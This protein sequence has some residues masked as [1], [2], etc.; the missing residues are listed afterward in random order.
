[1]AQALEKIMIEGSM[2]TITKIMEE[3][4]ETTEIETI[5]MEDPE[6]IEETK[7]IIL[8]ISFQFAFPQMNMLAE[9]TEMIEPVMQAT[10]AT[11]TSF[12]GLGLRMRWI[13]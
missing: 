7:K 12:L 2:N 5:E 3:E 6:E 13:G 4:G 10:I 11:M 9:T 1:M 8:P